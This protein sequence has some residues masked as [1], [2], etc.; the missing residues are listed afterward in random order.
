MEARNIIIAADVDDT[1]DSGGR[2]RALRV[3]AESA[4]KKYIAAKKKSDEARRAAKEAE[5]KALEAN[6]K[7]GTLRRELRLVAKLPV[8]AEEELLQ[9]RARAQQ[10]ED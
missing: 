2:L 8:G 3:A 10:V 5:K 4:E 6:E 1:P 9:I 7:F